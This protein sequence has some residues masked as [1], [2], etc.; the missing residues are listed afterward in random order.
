MLPLPEELYV[1]PLTRV[2]WYPFPLRSVQV[3]PEP[4]YEAVFPASKFKINPEVIIENGIG[5]V[6][7]LIAEYSSS[8]LQIPLATPPL[9]ALAGPIIP[10][11]GILH[12]Y[13]LNNFCYQVIEPEAFHW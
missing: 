5:Q 8:S 4:G 3:V 10:P 13:F 12:Q 1:G 7:A 2:P 9:M 11:F 6:A